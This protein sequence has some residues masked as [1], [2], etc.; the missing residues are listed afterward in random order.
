[1]WFECSYIHTQKTPSAA[2]DTFIRWW[3][4]FQYFIIAWLCYF[5]SY[6][7]MAGNKNKM[8]ESQ[9]NLNNTFFERGHCIFS[10]KGLLLHWKHRSFPSPPLFWKGKNLCHLIMFFYQK[11]KHTLLQMTSEVIFMPLFH[12]NMYSISICIVFV[13]L[14]TFSLLQIQLHNLCYIPRSCH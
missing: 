7:G 9:P 13:V 2:M 11:H 4:V 5:Q 3:I 6:P 12:N 1:M 10:A 14:S 8:P